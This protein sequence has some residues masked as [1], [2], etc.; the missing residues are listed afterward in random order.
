VFLGSA[1]SFRVFGIKVVKINLA[2][3]AG[4]STIPALEQANQ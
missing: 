2:Q 4:T 1:F 3:I